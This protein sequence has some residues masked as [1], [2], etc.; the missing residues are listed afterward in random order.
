MKSWQDPNPHQLTRACLLAR[1]RR[2]HGAA[3]AGVVCPS[4][5]TNQSGAARPT[6]PVRL[7]V[8]FAGNGFHGKEWWA[9][10]EGRG[11]ELGKVLQPLEP[12]KEKMLFHRRPV[13]RRGRQGRHSQ[14]PDRQPADRGGPGRRRRH[15]LRRQRGSAPRP[16]DRSSR[17]RCPAWCWAASRRSRPCTRATR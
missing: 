1:P 16:E 11:M 10:G 7:A 13:Q 14:C 2:D 8:L 5:A 3:V 6:P 17:P 9:K 4:G 12:F 15:S